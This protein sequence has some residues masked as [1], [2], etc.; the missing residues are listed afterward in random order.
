MIERKRFYKPGRSSL[1]KKAV[2]RQYSAHLNIRRNFTRKSRNQLCPQ[3]V[4]KAQTFAYWFSKFFRELG[5]K[6][7]TVATAVKK[8]NARPYKKQKTPQLD[9]RIKAQRLAYAKL[10]PVAQLVAS[11]KWEEEKHTIAFLDHTPTSLNGVVNSSHDPCWLT[12]EDKKKD[13]VPSAGSS[14]YSVKPQVLANF[15]RI[16]FDF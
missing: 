8:L 1:N 3:S 12:P 15:S 9:K 13:G 11:G 7:E 6:W 14:K 2:E 10:G 16:L 5:H 4:G